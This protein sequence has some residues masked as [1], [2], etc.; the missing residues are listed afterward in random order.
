MVTKEGEFVLIDLGMI[1]KIIKKG[2]HIEDCSVATFQG[3]LLF[4]SLRAMMLLT[5]SRRDDIS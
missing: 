4:S 3:N 5:T 1:K 2:K